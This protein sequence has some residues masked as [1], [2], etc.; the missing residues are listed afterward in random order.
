[1]QIKQCIQCKES[2]GRSY[3]M[4]N[5]EW[6]NRKFCS[7]KCYKIGRIETPI[8]RKAFLKECE[9]CKKDFNVIPSH[10]YTKFCSQNCY[11][12]NK[13]TRLKRKC[14]LCSKVFYATPSRIK[15]TKAKYCSNKCKDINNRGVNHY[16][17]KEM[18][19]SN[20]ALHIWVKRH[21]GKPNICE[22][23]RK[24]AIHWA[25]KSH[26]YK[27]DLNDWLSL[28]GSCH[29]KYDLAYLKQKA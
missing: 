25:N 12:L 18:G 19:F 11:G 27:R 7:Q 22:F 9:Y 2:F 13:R 26:K 16:L 17:W 3:K 14:H 29:K 23:C 28:C 15:F 8:I 21:R 5:K 20:A 6:E 10:S 1:M 24:K 4:N